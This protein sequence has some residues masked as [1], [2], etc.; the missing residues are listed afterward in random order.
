MLN[1]YQLQIFIAVNDR[2]TFSGAAEQFSL[3]QPGVSQ[4]IRALEEAYKV[5]LFNR[6]GP[7]IELTEAGQRL[8]EAARPLVRQAEQLEESFS[9]GL[10]E[11]RGRLNLV[12]SRS[13]AGV[14]YLLPPMLAEF[15]RRYGQ[16]RFSLV[17]A[18][19]EEA[20]ERLLDREVS[21]AMLSRPPRQK[22][23]ESK[24]LHSD[25]LRLVV[26]TDHAWHD[27]TVDWKALKGQPFL[28]RH[29]GSE[30]RRLTEAALR[31]VGLGLNDLEIVAELDSTEAIVMGVRAGL[32]LGLTSETVVRTYVEAGLV[33]WAQMAKPAQA[34]LDLRRETYLCRLANVP[35]PGRPLA[36]E[37]FWE[38]TQSPRTETKRDLV[39]LH[40]NITT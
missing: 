17:Q 36:Q 27:R 25:E 31:T 22:S 10:G 39:W 33:G 1:L 4:H 11:V 37:R 32:G 34:S 13:T 29:S 7:H 20:L 35:G 14:L 15:H 9:G 12:Y 19:E 16:V 5:R 2:G 23:V 40:Q 26:P 38:F 3:T 18:G 6:N 8:L 21:F 28:L 30:T 24:L